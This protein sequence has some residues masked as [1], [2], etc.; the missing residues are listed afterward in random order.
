MSKVI[1]KKLSLPQNA[2]LEEKLK[3]CEAHINDLENHLEVILNQIKE[4][5]GR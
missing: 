3:L 4:K 1:L 2:S 5:I